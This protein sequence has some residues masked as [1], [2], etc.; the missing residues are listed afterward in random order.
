[1]LFR[2][3]RFEIGCT[4]FA[5]AIM[6]AFWYGRLGEAVPLLR[7]SCAEFQKLDDPASEG[8]VYKALGY[9]LFFEGRFAE[10]LAL[11]HRE[12]RT[13]TDLG[14]LRLAGIAH[15]EVGECLL[16][17]GRYEEAEA[18]I[19]AGMDLLRDR[20]PA[21]FASR[22]RY[23]GDALL[24]QGRYRESLGSYQASL[25]AFEAT[26]VRTWMLTAL[27]GLGRAELG[28]GDR[29]SARE[30]A[31]KALRLYGKG[32]VLGFFVP[33]ALA[34]VA[35]LLAERG[36]AREALEL[37]ALA[38][39]QPS[40]ASSR[41][42]ADLYAQPIEAAAAGLPAEEHSAARARGQAAGLAE[43]V[44]RA[45]AAGDRLRAAEP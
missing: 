22:Q 41:W 34:V 44:E 31:L 6:A 11:K 26:G 20:A 8:M 33:M 40:L 15:A 43:A 10:N 4:L 25:R 45:L 37:Y 24:A 23:L 38:A 1:V 5:T 35:L 16:H 32:D 2:S 7:E 14:D 13:Y 42:F 29:A 36:Q 3:D 27:S 30:H 28:L 18:Q 12:L 21:Q 17:L 9:L 39:G 19:R